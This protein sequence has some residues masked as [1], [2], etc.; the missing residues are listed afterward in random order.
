MSEA[1]TAG[2][3]QHLGISVTREERSGSWG[4]SMQNHR[5]TRQWV[6]GYATGEAATEAALGWLLDAAWRGVLYPILQAAAAEGIVPVAEGDAP[7]EADDDNLLAPWLR[8]F[9]SETVAV[10]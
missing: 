5:M 4:W 3:L 2:V 6:G 7:D 8:A 10:Q 1:A 9:Q